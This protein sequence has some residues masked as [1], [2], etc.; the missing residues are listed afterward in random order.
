MVFSKQILSLFSE[1]CF[2]F[3]IKNLKTNKFPQKRMTFLKYLKTQTKLVRQPDR[4]PNTWAV[5]TQPIR[6]PLGRQ[7]PIA[8]ISKKVVMNSMNSNCCEIFLL[9]ST[10]LD[11]SW[12]SKHESHTKSKGFSEIM[13]FSWNRVS[14]KNFLES[15]IVSLIWTEYLI[16]TTKVPNIDL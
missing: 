12:K 1:S 13:K 6:S 8:R 14:K 15:C 10:S 2:A 9:S 11:W 3:W 16:T 4:Q 5:K 7:T